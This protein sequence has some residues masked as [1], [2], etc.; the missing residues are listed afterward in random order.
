MLVFIVFTVPLLHSISISFRS[1]S[2]RQSI[3]QSLTITFYLSLTCSLFIS[4]FL[5][6][7]LQ[8]TPPLPFLPIFLSLYL[9]LCLSMSHYLYLS[10][11]QTD[12]FSHLFFY[13]VLYLIGVDY[14][15]ADKQIKSSYHKLALKYHPDK[16]KAEG[17]E[18]QFKI[19]THAYSILIDKVISIL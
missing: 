11:T 8:Q 5:S 13:F 14:K 7:P 18:E 10:H 19:I 1:L 6:L 9:T 3:Y 4:I 15:S 16:N 12:H 17:A 2:L